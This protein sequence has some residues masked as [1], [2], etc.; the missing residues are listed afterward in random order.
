MAPKKFFNYRQ[1]RPWAENLQIV[2]QLGLTMAGCIIFCLF[3][4]RFL[5]G[6]LGTPGIFTILFIIFGIVGGAVV[7][8]R[9][10]M[11][12]LEPKTRNQSGTDDNNHPPDHPSGK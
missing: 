10:I 3:V 7:V 6:W 1:N 8:Y 4:G 12:I 2:A 11:E 9:Q 5:D